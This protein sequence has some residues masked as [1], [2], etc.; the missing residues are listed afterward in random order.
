MLLFLT[1]CGGRNGNHLSYAERSVEE[2]YHEAFRLVQE[3]SFRR[4]SLQFD[5]VERQHPYSIWARRALVM[6][7]YAYYRSGKYE[8]TILTLRRFIGLHPSNKSAPYAYY[9][10]AQCY[11]EQI[12]DVTREQRNTRLALDAFQDVIRRYPKT[13]YARNALVKMNVIHSQLAGKEMDIGRYYLSTHSYVAAINRFRNVVLS[14]QR[15]SYVE[16]ALHRLTEIYLT[17]GLREEA[18]S[19]VAV[20]GHNYPSSQWYEESYRMLVEND[21]TSQSAN[22]SWYHH[23]WGFIF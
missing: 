8:D 12:S 2:I 3:K 6:S 18:Q 20:L 9:L 11:Y 22:K 16:E 21:L 1:A 23:V 14:Y 7:A 17:L 5:E 4:A 13:D 15:T 10:I 19:S